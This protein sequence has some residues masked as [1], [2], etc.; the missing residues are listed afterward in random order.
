[1]NVQT[2][3]PNDEVLHH[4]PETRSKINEKV[5]EE[6]AGTEAFLTDT[7]GLKLVSEALTGHTE[8]AVFYT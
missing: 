2:K 4:A 7:Q 8:M 6:L 3:K 5:K 1:M